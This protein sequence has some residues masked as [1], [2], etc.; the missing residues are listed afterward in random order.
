MSDCESSFDMRGYAYA[1]RLD[2]R[3]SGI[4]IPTAIMTSWDRK[5]EQGEKKERKGKR[6]QELNLIRDYSN[7]KLKST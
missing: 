1:D 4:L 7:V 6:M 2:G 3:S 5:E